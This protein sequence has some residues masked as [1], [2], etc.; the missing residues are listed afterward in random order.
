[1][2]LGAPSDHKVKG[3]EENKVRKGIKFAMLATQAEDAKESYGC[4][5]RKSPRTRPTSRS[6][7][8]RRGGDAHESVWRKC[9]GDTEKEG[10]E[11]RTEQ[12]KS[13][14]HRSSP[15]R[16]RSGGAQFGSQRI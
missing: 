12:D 9:G 8:E 13:E 1:M 14:V 7:H 16:K 11:R 4:E 5:N 10:D 15:Q 3:E 2:Y 6:E